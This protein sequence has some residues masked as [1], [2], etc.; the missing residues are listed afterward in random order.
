VLILTMH[1]KIKGC[2]RVLQH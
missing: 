2:E 1:S